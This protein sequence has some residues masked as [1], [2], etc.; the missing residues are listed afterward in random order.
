MRAAITLY[1][2]AAPPKPCSSC[3]EGLTGGSD[4]GAPLPLPSSPCKGR[5][6]PCDREQATT[7]ERNPCAGELLDCE[8][9][10]LR[11]ACSS[12]WADV[13]RSEGRPLLSSVMS[14]SSAEAQAGGS[15]RFRRAAPNAQKLCSSTLTHSSS[16]G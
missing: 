5:V 10:W 15:W 13:T 2:I 14:R 7:G 12:A 4:G 8:A 1:T 6:W 3:S 9:P 16:W 11:L